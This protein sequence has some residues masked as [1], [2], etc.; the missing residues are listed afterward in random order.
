MLSS[1]Q[2]FGII[3]LQLLFSVTV[4]YSNYICPHPTYSDDD[5]DDENLDDEGYTEKSPWGKCETSCRIVLS[6]FSL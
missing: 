6:F 4:S 5:D 1:F 3:I 2:D